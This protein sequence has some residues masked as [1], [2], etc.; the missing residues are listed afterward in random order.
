MWPLKKEETMTTYRDLA[1]KAREMQEGASFGAM[2]KGT[3]RVEPELEEDFAEEDY[4]F[5][6]DDSR[7]PLDR[8]F[9]R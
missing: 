4:A 2:S 5:E 9:R 7:V 3:R 8:I 6:Q 1:E